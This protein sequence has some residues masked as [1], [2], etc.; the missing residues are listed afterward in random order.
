LLKGRTARFC[1]Q[2]LDRSGAFWHSESYDH[3]VHDQREYERALHYISNN[4]IKAGLVSDGQDWP[5]TY[6]AK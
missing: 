2:A 4:P 6:I 5:Y 3:V 1:N